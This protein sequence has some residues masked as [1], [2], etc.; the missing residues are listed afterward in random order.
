MKNFKT[1]EQIYTESN[2]IRRVGFEIEF[3]NLEISD[4]IELLESFLN[5][6]AKEINRYYYK[7]DSKFGEFNL[8]L[9]FE[10]LTK[11]K[12]K[13]NLE[14]ILNK[15]EIDA[16]LL[17]DIDSAIA[18]I[19]KQFVPL[20][21][22]S[23]PIEIDKIGY[24]EKLRDRLKNSGAFGTYRSFIYAF[25]LH[26]NIEIPS[27]DIDR[28]LSYFRA[29]LILSDYLSQ[30]SSINITRKLTPYIDNF[31]KEYIQ[32]VLNL[33]YNPTIEEFI[34]DYIEFNPTRNRILDMLPLLAFIDRDRVFSKLKDTKIK[35]RPTFHYRL[36]DSRVD[37]ESWS[38]ANEWN[39][40]I[41]VE[42]LANDKEEL[43]KL[44]R[45][46]LDYLDS[47]NPFKNWADRVYECL[48]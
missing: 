31:S 3:S 14:P 33:D 7:F 18:D 42:N 21:I 35:P 24:I 47:L 16:T 44:S 39:R 8:E 48:K 1:P 10:L 45:E 6:K 41:L 11:E 32:R 13:S 4:A 29:F 9:D 38:I 34:D 5:S 25:G 12:L 22:N 30:S 2:Q 36:P 23:P 40:W 37:D 20:E 46:Y 19:S 43:E 15:M 27:L 26:I 28:V 17:D